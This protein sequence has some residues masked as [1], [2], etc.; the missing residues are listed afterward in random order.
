MKRFGGETTNVWKIVKWITHHTKHYILLT[1]LHNHRC[2]HMC[3]LIQMVKG[4]MT[5][6]VWPS[7][8]LGLQNS[9]SSWKTKK[10]SLILTWKFASAR[11]QSHSGMLNE[12]GPK[13]LF[14][15]C[16]SLI[17][18]HYLKSFLPCR[19]ISFL[20]LVTRE[21]SWRSSVPFFFQSVLSFET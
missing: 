10:K 6:M 14:T 9:K 4:K 5:T 8:L 2:F 12:K 13:C 15:S 18:W 16:P 17:S 7:I 11:Q 20:Y 19:N 3:M 1:Y 21:E